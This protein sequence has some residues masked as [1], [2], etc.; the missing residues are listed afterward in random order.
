[1]KYSIDRRQFLQYSG[2]GL[3]TAS[4][5]ALLG[6]C[7]DKY[8]T[9]ENPEF[10]KVG[11]YPPVLDEVSETALKIEGTIPP[12]LSGLYVRNGPNSWQGSTDHFF[13]GDGMLH[14]IRLEQ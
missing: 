2:Y 13:M 14:G 5:T 10:W 6:G 11:N 9:A 8:N 12:E 3:A 1:M 7:G 4:A